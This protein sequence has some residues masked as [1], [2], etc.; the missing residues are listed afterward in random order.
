MKCFDEKYDLERHNKNQTSCS[1]NVL[2]LDK[3]Q[4]KCDW[5]KRTFTNKG[6]L[7]KHQSSIKSLCFNS[8]KQ[9]E[10]LKT[11]ETPAEYI[12]RIMQPIQINN[13]TINNVN[14]LKP[15][16][17]NISHITRYVLLEIL[18]KSF[19]NVCKDLMQ[20][21]YFN[22]DVPENCNWCIIYPKNEQGGMAFNHNTKIFER[23]ST[24]EI[25]D[26]KF[27]NMIDLV[28]PLMSDIY[29]D[30]ELNEKLSINQKKNIQRYFHHYGVSNISN[31][32]SE[33]YKAMFE[34]AYKN[35]TT[36]M[37]SWKDQGLNAKYLSLKF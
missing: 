3:Y 22:S 33:I 8:Q 12:N 21:I 15:G 14:I 9:F 4:Y 28:F 10:L 30:K 26:E 5:C 6:G 7:I 13:Q 34:I 18:N 31:E 17:E 29:N 11:H 2:V 19:T 20:L 35:K 32:S 23:K 27:S 1:N 25:I 36:S 24:Q 16:K 37:K